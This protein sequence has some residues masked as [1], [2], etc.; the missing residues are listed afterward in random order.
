MVDFNRNSLCLLTWLVQGWVST[1]FYSRL[2][3]ILNN[4]TQVKLKKK[5]KDKWSTLS[6]SFSHGVFT[7]VKDICYVLL[8]LAYPWLSLINWVYISIRMLPINQSCLGQNEM[9]MS[10][11]WNR[12]NPWAKAK[13]GTPVLVRG[14]MLVSVSPS[15]SLHSISFH[16]H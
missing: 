13:L 5:R 9:S 1:A 2:F 4:K 15:L 11:D 10:R 3:L 16:V 12:F 7:P 14:V 6:R 8:V